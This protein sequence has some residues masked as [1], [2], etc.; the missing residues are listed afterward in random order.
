MKRVLITGGTGFVGANLARR[1][2]ADGHAVH[3]L[4]GAGHRTWRLADVLDSLTRHEADLRDADAVCRAVAAVRPEWVFHLAAHGAY[5][6]QTDARAIMATNVLGTVHLVEACRQIGFEVFV[7]TGSSAEYGWKDHAPAEDEGL[8]PNSAYAVAKASA[9]LFCRQVA[10]AARLSIP[11]LR[12]YSVYGPYE[13]PNRFLP[14]LVV[15]GLEGAYP[16][17]ADPDIARD[18][19]HVN[20]VTDAYLRL[21]VNP[22]ADP[23]AVYN[24]GTGV[25]TT[26]RQAAEAAAGVFRYRGEPAWGSMPN[27]RWDTTVWVADARKARRELGWAPRTPFAGGLRAFRAWFEEHPELLAH[28][29]AALRPPRAA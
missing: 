13:E 24:L 12:L 29:R 11:T 5:S 4:V 23:G 28:Y 17:L 18:Y 19:I 16:P 22:P 6:W 26:L 7:N 1:L 2:L 10:R 21:A 20:D 25:Q 9:T 15:Y 14:A 8:E 3:L 27:R